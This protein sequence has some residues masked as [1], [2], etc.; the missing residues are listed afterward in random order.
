MHGYNPKKNQCS[1]GH[2][3]R[4]MTLSQSTRRRT[5][6]IIETGGPNDPKIDINN[7]IFL[8][9]LCDGG[10]RRVTLGRR[11]GRR[12]LQLM[13]LSK[14]AAQITPESIPITIYMS[15]FKS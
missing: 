8:K 11:A 6:G 7:N 4:Q 9:I 3:D 1:C 5:N 10:G 12:T 13:P 14:S 15:F 2:M